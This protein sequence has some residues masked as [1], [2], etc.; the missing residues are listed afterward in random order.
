MAVKISRLARCGKYGR[1]IV[2]TDRQGHAMCGRR[3]HAWAIVL[4]NNQMSPYA[5][6]KSMRF[7]PEVLSILRL[8]TVPLTLFTM[9]AFVVVS[10]VF[11]VPLTA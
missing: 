9:L 7:T 8:R 5:K 1:R 10:T 2:A 6:G 11:S 4:E 3:V